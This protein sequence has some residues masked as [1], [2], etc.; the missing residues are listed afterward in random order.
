MVGILIFKTELA[1][2]LKSTAT[3]LFLYSV[4]PQIGTLSESLFMSFKN[5]YNGSEIYVKKKP[6]YV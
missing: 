4:S 1:I 6:T 5:L 2:A 3:I